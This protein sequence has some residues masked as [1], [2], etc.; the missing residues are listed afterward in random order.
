MSN[1]HIGGPDHAAEINKIH[2]DL[3]SPAILAAGWAVPA[4]PSMTFAP[5]ETFA[6]VNAGSPS[7]LTYVYQPPVSLALAGGDGTYWVAVHADTWSPVSGWSRRV[8]SHY[9]WQTSGTHPGH[10]PGGLTGLKVTVA[11]G[12]I[13]AMEPVA[14][15]ANRV[16]VGGARGQLTYATDF[17]W[18]PAYVREVGTIESQRFLVLNR[19]E[20]NTIAFQTDLMAGTGHWALY[21]SG[22]AQ[23]LIGGPLTVSGAVGLGTA[24]VA[25]YALTTNGHTSLS[26][27]VGVGLAATAITAALDVNGTTRLRGAVTADYVTGLG[28]APDANFTLRVYGTSYFGG[29]VG[30]GGVPAYP[31]DVNG[32]ARILGAGYVGGALTAAGGLS[33]TGA[34]S[35]SEFVGAGGAA[36]GGYSLRSYANSYFDG[37]VG[38]ASIPVAGARV[39]IGYNKGVESGLA[40]QQTASDAGNA[41]VLFLNNGGGIC[42]TIT[43]SAVAT[44][45]N[46]T[47]D[48]RAKSGIVPLEGSVPILQAL[49]PVAFRWRATGEAGVG[50]VADEV[51]AV[52]PAAVSGTPDGETLQGMD[53]SKLLPYVVGTLHTIL[54]RLDALENTY[55]RTD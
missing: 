6:Y 32:A 40:I 31:L 36:D 35:V 20:D 54:H 29:M 48:R 9:L 43:T 30:V 17:T 14:S 18:T 33:V 27:N 39:I 7:R 34:A 11:G 10:P 50:F 55:A 23:S 45:Y 19:T 3:L 13:T 5:F 1:L 2:A 26:A 37:K 21:A 4:P 38:F 44:A 25:G 52:V 42:G 15:P 8:G 28:G 51:Q 12:A 41:S 53:M 24:P 47:S 49:T 22:N 16:A 46:T